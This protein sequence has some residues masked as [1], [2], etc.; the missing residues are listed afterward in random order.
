MSNNRVLT[1]LALAALATVSCKADKKVSAVWEPIGSVSIAA[2]TAP[3]LVLKIGQ[4]HQFT[5]E[6]RLA[7]GELVD[8]AFTVIYGSSNAAVASVTGSGLATAMGPGTAT[9]TATVEGVKGTAEIMVPVP[10]AEVLLTPDTATLDRGATLQLAA[11]VYD[12]GGNVLADPVTFT[13]GSPAVATVSAAGLVTAVSVGEAIITAQSGGFSGISTITVLEPVVVVELQASTLLIDVGDTVQFSATP[14]DGNGRALNRPVT[15][16]SSNTSVATVD[17]SGRIIGS[18]VG[19]TTISASAGGMHGSVNLDVQAAAASIIITSNASGNGPLLIDSTLQLTATVK[20]GAGNT[21]N[22]NVSWAS[23]NEGIAAVDNN[24]LVTGVA[25]GN[26]TITATSGRTAGT[27]DVRVVGEGGE[28]SVGNNLSVPVV[29]AEGI[30][31]TGLAV[32]TDHGLRPTAEEGIVVDALPFFYSGNTPDCDSY[33]CQQGTNTWQAEWLDG[34]TGGARRAEVAWGDNL[35]HHQWN[36]HNQIR[37]EVVLTDLDAQLQGFNMPYVV[38]SGSTEM[39]GTDGT[40][41]AMSATIYSSTPRLIIEKLDDVTRQPIFTAFNAS[42]WEAYGQDGPGFYGAEVNVAGKIIYGFNF[43]IR[44]VA[45]PSD[46]HKF[47][48]W[49]LTFTL[50]PESQVGGASIP[51]NV[52]LIQ[53]ASPEESED[54]EP[55]LFTPELSTDGITSWLDIEVKS[56]SGGGGG[57]H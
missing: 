21:L 26:A 51:R 20:D 13:S 53:L 19:S 56:A 22:R 36:T 1:G 48:W 47:G 25:S 57:G 27:F 14:K 42:V 15:W 33:Y 40:N 9:I 29:F 4:T 55:L 54:S 32:A 18:G 50:D 46:I 44:D 10:V 2:P 34:S 17:E 3:P 45:V 23:G 8:R 28:T 49:R 31:V 52:Q 7:S 38:G 41:A 39:Q 6:V 43:T 5:A 11:V 12:A 37:V 35:T 16:G 24:G 30:G